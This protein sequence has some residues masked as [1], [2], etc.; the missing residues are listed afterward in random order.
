MYVFPSLDH[1][2]VIEKRKLKIS[3]VSKM[4]SYNINKFIYYY[5]FNHIIK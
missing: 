5:I 3:V 4:P 2:E 1:E